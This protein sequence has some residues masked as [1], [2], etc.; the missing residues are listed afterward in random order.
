ME[1]EIPVPRERGTGLSELYAG[2]APRAGRLAYVLTGDPDL[3]EDVAQEAFSRLIVRLPA[4]R[5]TDAIDAY[6]RRSVVNLCR[7]HWRRLGRERAFLRAQGPAVTS[8]TVALPDVAGADALRRALSRL[9]YRQ[10]AALV[11]RFF[12]DLSE[13]ETAR[14]L[15]CAV[16]T[17][18]SLASRGLAALREELEDEDAD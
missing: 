2:H 3:A 9:P 18:K 7:K 13:R 1:R 15:G 17:V 4:L 6:L 8:T 16:G 10:R 12:E 11:L 5:N 14:A